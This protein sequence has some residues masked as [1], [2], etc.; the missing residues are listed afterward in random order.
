MLIRGNKKAHLE[1]PSSYVFF[2]SWLL[3]RATKMIL[4]NCSINLKQTKK[5]YISVDFGAVSWID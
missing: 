4:T 3:V 2:V 1:I 5:H